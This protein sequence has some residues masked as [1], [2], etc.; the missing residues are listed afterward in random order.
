VTGS[1]FSHNS[2][3][4][5]ANAIAFANTTFRGTI[6]SNPLGGGIN[7]ISTVNTPTSGGH[8]LEDG[9]APGTC[10]FT[11]ATDLH[12]APM[13]DSSLADNGGPTLTRA[14]LAGSPAI[15]AGRRFGA[16]SDQRGEPRPFDLDSIANGAGGDGADIGAF[17]VQGTPAATEVMLKA[18]KMR[19]PK[20]RKVRLRAA[21]TPCPGRAGD[22]VRLFRGTRQIK[23]SELGTDCKATF[24]V[25]VKRTATFK[26]VVPADTEHLTGVS[27][28]VRVRVKR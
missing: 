8:N 23:S 20:G 6:V 5:S 4:V 9:S 18:S 27:N 7:C 2:A 1:T 10:G 25:K 15:D 22:P 17:E 19:V 21:A 13:L 12:A 26:T 14:L 3:P 11:Q 28:K 24:R 16:T